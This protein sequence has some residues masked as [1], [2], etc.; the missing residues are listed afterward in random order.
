MRSDEPVAQICRHWLCWRGLCRHSVVE[1]GRE[2]STESV[3]WQ[4]RLQQEE[5]QEE[6]QKRLAQ[7]EQEEQEEE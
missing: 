2:D 4:E 1:R 7:E 5:L 3:Q 6:G